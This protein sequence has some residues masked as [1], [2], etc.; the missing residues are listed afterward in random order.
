LQDIL[1]PNFMVWT[2]FLE[3]ISEVIAVNVLG[4]YVGNGVKIQ[5]WLSVA[6][7]SSVSVVGLRCRCGVQNDHVSIKT[8]LVVLGPIVM[9]RAKFD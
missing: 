2:C 7:V 4:W 5:P 9:F 8:G 1:V 3:S 6:R